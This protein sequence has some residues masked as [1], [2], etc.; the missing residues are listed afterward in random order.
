MSR[1]VLEAWNK[2]AP[3][4]VW[5]TYWGQAELS[6]LGTVGWFKTLED[7]PG[8]DPSWIGKPVTTL[9]ARVVDD[10]GK[11]VQPDGVGELICRSPSTML[12]YYKDP[13]RTEAV[14]QDGW[15]HTGDL[16][17]ID[18]RGNLFFFDRKKDMIK[19]GGINVSSFEVED[20]LYKHPSVAEVAVVG[21]QDPYWSEII[22][23]AIV[24]RVG[25]EIQE[26][27]IRKFCGERM[28]P[29]KVPKKVF[30]VPQLP[31]DAQGKMLKRELRKQL[32]EK[33]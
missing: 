3:E 10:N 29:Y 33:H 13:E 19:T 17:R 21:L 26:E 15:V 18:E 7:I 30:V 11:D 28:A 22:V 27:E 5:G 32:A 14:F 4:I 6:Q 12:G 2:K 24:P 31:R 23:A 20:I 9:E 1:Q 8:L 16:V 25:T